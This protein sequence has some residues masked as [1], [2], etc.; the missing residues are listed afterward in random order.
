[1]RWDDLQSVQDISIALSLTFISEMGIIVWKG[2]TITSFSLKRKHFHPCFKLILH[3]LGCQLCSHQ[4]GF[5]CTARVTLQEPVALPQLSRSVNEIQSWALEIFLAPSKDRGNGIRRREMQFLKQK[6]ILISNC[7][8]HLST[9]LWSF[10]QC[11]DWRNKAWHSPRLSRHLRTLPSQR[12]SSS[13]RESSRDSL[14]PLELLGAPRAPRPPTGLGEE[15]EELPAMSSLSSRGHPDPTVPARHKVSR[16]FCPGRGN[17]SKP[18]G[19]RVPEGTEQGH[20]VSLNASSQM[21]HMTLN[22]TEYLFSRFKIKQHLT[23]PHPA[24]EALNPSPVNAAP[25][26]SDPNILQKSVCRGF[27]LQGM[28]QWGKACLKG[29]DPPWSANWPKMVA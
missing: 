27:I 5:R 20:T 6:L 8:F 29:T 1:M 18:V 12:R 4:T 11:S 21:Q 24:W 19:S 10:W 26:H 28:L 2:F 14:L 13:L 25:C 9:M 16:A 15:E 22:L 3:I 17:N 23:L 7:Y